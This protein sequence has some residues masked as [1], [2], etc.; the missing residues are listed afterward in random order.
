MA[1]LAAKTAGAIAIVG[2]GTAVPGTPG[3]GRH[4]WRKD[5]IRQMIHVGQARH[6]ARPVTNSGGHGRNWGLWLSSLS[7]FDGRGCLLRKSGRDRIMA[8]TAS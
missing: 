1:I 4:R 5:T 3:I 6:L 2:V 8:Q 7:G